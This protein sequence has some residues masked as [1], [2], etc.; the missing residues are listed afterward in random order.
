MKLQAT[1]WMKFGFILFSGRTINLNKQCLLFQY[2]FTLFLKL[3]DPM[4]HSLRCFEHWSSSCC[5]ISSKS[6]QEGWLPSITE[7][8]FW[9]YFRSKKFYYFSENKILLFI[10]FSYVLV[11]L[12]VQDMSVCV[13]VLYTYVV[14]HNMEYC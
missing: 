1:E 5:N 6:P 8:M 12:C 7:I 4:P 14:V 13:V 3:I 10:I 11:T 9:F 2:W